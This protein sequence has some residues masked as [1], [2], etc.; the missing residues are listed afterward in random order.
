MKI[1]GTSVR[2]VLRTLPGTNQC[3]KLFLII[4]FFPR[5]TQHEGTH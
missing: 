2:E 5:A 1:K 4:I 3:S